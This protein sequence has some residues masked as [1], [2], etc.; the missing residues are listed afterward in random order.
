MS[1]LQRCLLR[2]AI[3]ERLGITGSRA[4]LTVVGKPVETRPMP[5][6]TF[7]DASLT[8]VE[9]A[10]RWREGKASLSELEDTDVLLLGL[11][12]LLSDARAV[13]A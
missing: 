7:H 3:R 11:R 2:A 6:E 5:E 8:I 10:R 9:F 13:Q 4:K 12:R 1:E